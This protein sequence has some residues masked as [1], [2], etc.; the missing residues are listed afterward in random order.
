M[1]ITEVEWIKDNLEK[2]DDED[3]SELNEF[4]FFEQIKKGEIDLPI[5][6]LLELWSAL[7]RIVKKHGGYL[8]N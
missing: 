2:L 8:K 5:L 1:K 3:I 6:R 4:D 7:I